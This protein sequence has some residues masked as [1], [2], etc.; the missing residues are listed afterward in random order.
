MLA[1]CSDLEAGSKE[2]ANWQRAISRIHSAGM[3]P[4]NMSSTSFFFF[5]FLIPF[6]GILEV[7]LTSGA[8][9][10]S[11]KLYLYK[12]RLEMFYALQTIWSLY[13]LIS[14]V[15]GAQKEPQ[16]VGNG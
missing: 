16:T 9:S 14:F 4:Q 5:L 13:Q 8:R 2:R 12:A 11:G 10:V 1:A 6:M 7:I 15:T 3:K